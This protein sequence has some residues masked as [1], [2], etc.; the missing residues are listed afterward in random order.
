MFYRP[1]DG[2]GLAHNPF[3]AVVSPRPIA[4]ISTRDSTGADNLAPYSFFNAVA[5]EPP[6]VVFGSSEAK[7]DRDGTKDSLGNI[8]ETGVFCI[9]IVEFAARDAMNASSAPHPRSVDEFEAAGI[10]KTPC[11]TIPCCRVAAAPAALECRLTRIVRL[12]GAANWAI[13]GAVTGVYLRDDCL[14]EGRFDVTRY[15]PLARLG[16]RDYA[17]VREVFTMTRPTRPA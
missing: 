5:S 15:Q 17:V 14:V 8:R 12:A 6:Q 11:E 9:N 2:H 10:A 1:A 4:W 3:H 13:F 16:Y 7:P